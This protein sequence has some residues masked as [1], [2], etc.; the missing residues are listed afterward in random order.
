LGQA[1]VVITTRLL[2]LPPL[3]AIE[4]QKALAAAA[5]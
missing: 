5:E 1:I 2:P 3:L 4:K